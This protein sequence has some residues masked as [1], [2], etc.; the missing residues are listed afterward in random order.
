MLVTG[1]SGY[2]GAA[3]LRARPDA[4]G[5]YLTTPL[6]GGLRLDVRDSAAV[7]DAVAGHDAVI[8]TA[9]VQDDASVIVDGTAAVADAC[10]RAGARLVHVSTDVVFD[11]ALGRPYTEDDEP[12]P[13]TDYGRAKLAA[14]RTV[15]E[16]CPGAAIARTSLIY[17]GPPHEPSRQEQLALDSEMAFFTDELRSPVQVHDLAAA[18]LDLATSNGAATGV[19]HLGGAHGVS[20]HEFARLVVAARGGDPNTTRRASFRDLG[21]ERPADCRLASSR[22]RA[23]RGIRE[24]LG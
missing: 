11:G 24:V 15:A 23:L 20:R 1:G 3:L 2:L 18:L 12:N 17:G 19:L 4:V 5:T 8:H 13:I 21:L 6:Q 22:T 16:R 14:E 7:A 10:A 9:Y